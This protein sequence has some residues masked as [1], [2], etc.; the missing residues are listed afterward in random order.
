MVYYNGTGT[1]TITALVAGIGIFFWLIMIALVV[2][3]IVITW[4]F[5]EKCGQEGWK[6]LIPI[7]REVVLFQRISM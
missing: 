3:G 4:K 6:S 5:F 1:Q 7:Y 2:I